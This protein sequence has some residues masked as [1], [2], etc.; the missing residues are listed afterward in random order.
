MKN[1][2]GT[3]KSKILGKN[4][5]ET[6]EN[7]SIFSI[8]IFSLMLSVSIALSAIWPKGIVAS[9]S[10]ISS[11]LVFIFTLSLV[12]IWIIKEV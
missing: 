2:V 4:R 11:F 3:L 1:V 9:I 10:M 7:V 8:I 5:L 6:F 12:I